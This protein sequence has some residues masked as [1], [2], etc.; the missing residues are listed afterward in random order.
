M[1]GE[2]S[3]LPQGK[4]SR[5]QVADH[6]DKTIGHRGARVM[7]GDHARS[8]APV[9][10]LRAYRRGPKRHESSR[11]SSRGVLDRGTMSVDHQ[12]GR[13]PK[14]PTQEGPRSKAYTR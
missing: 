13:P 6:Q 12:S 2:N 1:V 10:A 14:A 11:L 3:P 8:M 5:V 9:E 4:L 7:A